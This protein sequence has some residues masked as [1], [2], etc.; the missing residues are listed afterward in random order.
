MIRRGAAA[1]Y[2]CLDRDDDAARLRAEAAVL[3]Y[4]LDGH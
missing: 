3:C 1:E 4:E 2:E